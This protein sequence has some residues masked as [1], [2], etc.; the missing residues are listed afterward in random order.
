MSLVVAD[1]AEVEW[2]KR[3]L[4]ANAGSEDLILGLFKS[5]TTPAESDTASTYTMANFTGY[6]A[7][8]LTSS[9]TGS[10]WAVPTTSTG[11]TSSAYGTNAVFTSSDVTPQTVYGL[12]Y[13]FASSG[14][15]AGAE[16]FG[17]GKA[18]GNGDSLTAVPKWAFD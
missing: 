5:N 8:T 2:G 3:A 1:V 17:V 15:L 9:Q 6:S 13:T 7:V 10:T 14:I 11:V 4:Y 16:A 18:M 12:R